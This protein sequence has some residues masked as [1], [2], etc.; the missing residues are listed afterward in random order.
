VLLGWSDDPEQLE[1]FGD[2]LRLAERL[3]RNMVVIKRE[4][5]R[6]RWATPPGDIHIWWHGRRNGPLMLILAH[7]LAQNPEF[8]RRD[9]YLIH[10]VPEESAR[11]SAHEHLV[12]VTRRAR[13]DAQ[14]MTVVYSELREAV[15]NT[16]RDAAIVF[17]GFHPPVKGE[18]VQFFQ[19][20]EVLTDDLRDVVLVCAAQ[21]LDIDS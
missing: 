10:A 21:P 2:V 1:R 4:E 14:P 7:L 9:V 15:V 18:H 6:E 8:R 13:V 16:S 12:D 20:I 19:D 3:Q 11:E 17:F 5:H